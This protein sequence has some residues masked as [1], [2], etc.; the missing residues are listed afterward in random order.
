MSAL[1]DPSPPRALRAGVGAAV[2]VGFAAVAHRVG[3]GQVD[4]GA[5]AWTYALLIGPAWWLA[6]R[7]RSWGALAVTQLGG[8][9]VAHLVLAAA[10]PAAEAHHETSHVPADAMLLAHLAAAALSAVWLVRGER[11][12]WRALRRAFVTVLRRILG[13][14]RPPLR[15]A[16]RRTSGG[17]PRPV[18]GLRHVVS[19]RG[20]P[21]PLLAV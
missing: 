9:Q 20:P 8:Q 3:H 14:P 21:R 15:A 5:A 2:A 19:R 7:Q 17:V 11:R 10:R 12:A 16:A 4:V 1:L 18:D 13:T 6:R